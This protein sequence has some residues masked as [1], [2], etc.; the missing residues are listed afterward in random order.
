VIR[1]LANTV[2]MLVIGALLGLFAGFLWFVSALP[3]KEIVLDRSADGIVALTGGNSRIVD[4]IELLAQGRGKRLLISGVHRTTTLREIAR[5]A[6]QFERYILCC[7]DLDHSALNTVGN[8]A[9]TRRWVRQQNFRSLIIVTSS[10][11]MPRS[12]AELSRQMPDIELIPYPVVSEKLRTEPWWSH[13]PTARLLI[14][15]YLKY[16]VVQVRIR[17]EPAPDNT[18]VARGRD[19]ARS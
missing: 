10:Y 8:A 4:A 9:E 6:P 5:V 16:M 2:T 11:H 13:P 14:S 15:E 19:G 17:L 1:A 18:D 3:N 12:M 7:T